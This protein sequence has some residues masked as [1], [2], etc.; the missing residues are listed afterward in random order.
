MNAAQL[1]QF[2]EN[3][4]HLLEIRGKEEDEFPILAYKRAADTFREHEAELQ[5][6]IEEGA[7]DTLPGIGRRIAEKVEELVQTGKVKEYE[8]LIRDIPET[9]LDIMKVPSLGPKKAAVLLRELNVTD[10]E[11]FKTALK[12]GEMEGLPRFGK[13]TVE[14][15]KEG[16]KMVEKVQK[17]TPR[18]EVIPIVEKILKEL[19]KCKEIKK[20]EVAGSFRRKE[21]TVGDIDILVVGTKREVI[22][23]CVTSLPEVQQ[24][25]GKGDTK[26]SVLLKSGLQVDVRMIKEKSWGAAMQYFTGSKA[27]NVELRIIAK[28]KGL[29]INEYGVYEVKGDKE[30]KIA[31][32]T[33]EDVYATLG[34]ECP[35][36]EDRQASL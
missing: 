6:H 5:K 4:A 14:K 25:L 12:G 23:K 17:R 21:K 16:L 7:L 34:M 1:A 31:G 20:M 35:K 10:L 19:K 27:H 11:S 18:E 22:A 33:E 15:F 30:K 32:E 9:L 29:K 36:P 8:K 26:V 3:F 24:I 28:K 2:F 13:K